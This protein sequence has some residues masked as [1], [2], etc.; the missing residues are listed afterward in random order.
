MGLTLVGYL[1]PV[2]D[3]SLYGVHRAS[4]PLSVLMPLGFLNRTSSTMGSFE[5][6]PAMMAPRGR[7]LM[8]RIGVPRANHPLLSGTSGDPGIDVTL[9]LSTVAAAWDSLASVMDVCLQLLGLEP[10]GRHSAGIAVDHHLPLFAPSGS[11][12]EDV[13][14]DCLGCLAFLASTSDFSWSI[15]TSSPL[16]SSE[17]SYQPVAPSPL[18]R[19]QALPECGSLELAL[20]FLR[21]HL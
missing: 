8:Y 9:F 19:H 10:C 3:G 6:C 2:Q 14:V 4:P 13:P 16:Q 21:D 5:S 20:C 1:F 11:A 18:H 15:A 12:E 7:S 17:Y